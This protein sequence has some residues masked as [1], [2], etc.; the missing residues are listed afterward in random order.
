MVRRSMNAGLLFLRIQGSFD[1]DGATVEVNTTDGVTKVGL[2][3]SD[4]YQ[5]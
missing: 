1:D 5:V 3:A 2:A 4:A